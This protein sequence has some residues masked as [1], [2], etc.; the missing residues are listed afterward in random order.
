MMFVYRNKITG[1]VVTVPCEIDS[2]DLEPLNKT[3]EKEKKPETKKPTRK[4]A[5]K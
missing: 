2:P 5:V 3:T 1:I 4:K